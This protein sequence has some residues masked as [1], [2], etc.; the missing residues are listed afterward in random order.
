MIQ[1][2]TIEYLNRYAIQTWIGQGVYSSPPVIVIAFRFAGF[3]S[4]LGEVQNGQVAML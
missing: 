1:K 4:P 3:F 2:R